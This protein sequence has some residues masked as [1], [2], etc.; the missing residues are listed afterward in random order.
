MATAPTLDSFCPTSAQGKH[1]I[2]VL[3]VQTNILQCPLQ[4]RNLGKGL[5]CKFFTSCQ[6]RGSQ[7]T[8]WSWKIRQE[9]QRC[10]QPWTSPPNSNAAKTA[11]KYGQ[12]SLTIAQGLLCLLISERGAIQHRCN[13]DVTRKMFGEVQNPLEY[14][15]QQERRYFWRGTGHFHRGLRYAKYCD[16]RKHMHFPDYTRPEDVSRNGVGTRISTL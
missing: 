14:K 9:L 4:R 10:M 2:T 5:Q 16:R 15:I 13:S 7:P 11:P 6:C 1:T 12:T 8:L 3:P